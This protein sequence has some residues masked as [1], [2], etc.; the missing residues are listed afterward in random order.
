M[1]IITEE[2]SV[3]QKLIKLMQ[4]LMVILS[5]ITSEGDTSARQIL[6]S[7]RD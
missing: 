6:M 1:L 7:K 5:N 3:P 4:T 2:L